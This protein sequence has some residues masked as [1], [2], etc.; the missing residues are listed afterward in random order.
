MRIAHLRLAVMLVLGLTSVGSMGCHAY[1]AV[2]PANVG[3]NSRVRVTLRSG[4]RFV[5]KGATST[6]DSL[7]GLRFSDDNSDRDAPFAI[8]IA[9]VAKVEVVRTD[10]GRSVAGG[11]GLVAILAAAFFAVMLAMAGG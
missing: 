6:A 2:R 1:Q 8:A 11:A 5:L 10:V 3:P 7:R 9:D 4:E